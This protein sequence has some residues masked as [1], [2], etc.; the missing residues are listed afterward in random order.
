MTLS[1]NSGLKVA[2]T[3]LPAF[4]RHQL[5]PGMTLQKNLH[6]FLIV[7]GIFADRRVRT[8]VRFYAEKRSCAHRGGQNSTNAFVKISLVA[9]A[10]LQ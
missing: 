9:T 6:C 8:A 2:A 7:R 10:R 1:A 3:L 5:D 4:G